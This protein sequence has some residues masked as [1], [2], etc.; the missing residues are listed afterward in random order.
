[1]KRYI[2]VLCFSANH[3]GERTIEAESI[4]NAWFV[5]QR[6]CDRM[7]RVR[8]TDAAVQCIWSA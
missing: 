2:M 8:G 1:M 3:Y 5:A 6:Y 4:E 7:N